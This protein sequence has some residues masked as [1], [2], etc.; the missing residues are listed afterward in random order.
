M[1]AGELA[2]HR[3]WKLTKQ[4]IQ[5]GIELSDFKAAVSRTQRDSAF[6][7]DYIIEAFASDTVVAPD[8]TQAPWKFSVGNINLENIS[9]KFSDRL[10]GNEIA[11]DMGTLNIS[12]E[13]LDLEQSVFLRSLR[14]YSRCKNKF[15]SIKLSPI[16]FSDLIYQPGNNA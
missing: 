15:P 7:F 5:S 9:I 1:Y 3:S 10:M 16:L 8:T 12:M 11:L 6:N 13:E 14:F 4:T 2:S